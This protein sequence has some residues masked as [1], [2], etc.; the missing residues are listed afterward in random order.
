MW[1]KNPSEY[2]LRASLFSC[3]SLKSCS[4]KWV[5]YT[6][7]CHS[8]SLGFWL[9]VQMTQ[10]AQDLRMMLFIRLSN[11]RSSS[12][13]QLNIFPPRGSASDEGSNGLKVASVNTKSGT[14]TPA[15][16]WNSTCMDALRFLQASQSSGSECTR[17]KKYFSLSTHTKLDTWEA[18]CP[19]GE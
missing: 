10:S 12:S 18:I 19:N 15:I 9:Q 5:D 16:R 1:G 7:H 17:Q 2:A 13:F 14:Q 11:C 8:R 3:T 4:K 6:V